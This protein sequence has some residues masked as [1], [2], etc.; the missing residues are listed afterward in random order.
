MD[1]QDPGW[2]DGGIRG[3]KDEN[4]ANVLIII[5]RITGAQIPAEV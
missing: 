5:G 2:I 3:E 4:R 1:R